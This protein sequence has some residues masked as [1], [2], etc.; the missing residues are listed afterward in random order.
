MSKDIEIQPISPEMAHASM[1]LLPQ[2]LSILKHKTPAKHIHQVQKPGGKYPYVK[3][4]YAIEALNGMFFGMWSARFERHD[5]DLENNQVTV[6]CEI[7][8]PLANGSEVTKGGSGGAELKRYGEKHKKSG[9]IINKANDYKAAESDALKKAAS[10]FGL[11]SDV[12]GADWSEEMPPEAEL[13]E[14]E[15][16]EFEFLIPWKEKI[17]AAL[18]KKE[19]VAIGGEI[20]KLKINAAQRKYLAKITQEAITKFK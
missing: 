2:Q 16:A 18:D 5:C 15:D 1:T 7:S 3:N 6:Y 12:Y 8:I 11:F 19:I 14:M 10:R 4:Q 13:P 20:A 17:E 9:Q